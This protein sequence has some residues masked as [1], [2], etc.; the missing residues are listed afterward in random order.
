M[1]AN[2]KI[3]INLCSNYIREDKLAMPYAIMVTQLAKIFP[4]KLFGSVNANLLVGITLSETLISEGFF[5][6]LNDLGLVLDC[7]KSAIRIFYSC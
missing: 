3:K 6:T 5:N 7:V 4:N 2:R 1:H